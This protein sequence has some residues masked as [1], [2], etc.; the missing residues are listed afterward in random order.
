MFSATDVITVL[1]KRGSGKT[2]LSR[3][4]Q[5][6]FP[7]LVIFDRLHEYQGQNSENF[8][9]VHTFDEYCAAILASVGKKRFT[10]LYQ[11]DLEQD[12]HA[13]EFNQALRILYYRGSAC[14]VIEEVHNFATAHYLPKWF[15]EILL[16]GRHQNL[17]L[18]ATSQRPAELHKTLL[19][20]CHHIFCGSLHEK[21]DINYLSSV[22][23]DAA[24]S[25]SSL[26]IGRFLHYRPGEDVQIV[27]NR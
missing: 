1:G 25:V 26:K 17:A 14:A 11:F 3:K 24:D 8:W 23:G 7:R 12:S 6:A 10:I 15:K 21:N 5:S 22:L 4:L 27:T 2:T 9:T 18:I 19:S 16:T 13:E 20:Q